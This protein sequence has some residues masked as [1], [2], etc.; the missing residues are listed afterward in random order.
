MEFRFSSEPLTSKN[1]A[2]R[3]SGCWRTSA[4]L[5][6]VRVMTRLVPETSNF[7]VA[8]SS[9]PVA[10]EMPEPLNVTAVAP[11]TDVAA[12]ASAAETMGP[13]K[14][15]RNM[16]RIPFQKDAGGTTR[17]PRNSASHSKGVRCAPNR[18]ASS[19]FKKS[20]TIAAQENLNGD[21]ANPTTRTLMNQ[22]VNPW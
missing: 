12:R 8:E 20:G 17:N 1:T 3:M 15:E 5:V 9:A 4:A 19:L 2:V 22:T 16:L 21:H 6:L 14:P 7:A 11:A 10:L 18:C 13:I